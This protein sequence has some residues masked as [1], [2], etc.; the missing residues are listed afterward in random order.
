MEKWDYAFEMF[1]LAIKR[2]E[3]HMLNYK[4][5]LNLYFPMIKSDPRCDEIIQ[6]IGLPI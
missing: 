3:G 4:F 2:K 1:N 6:K 5:W